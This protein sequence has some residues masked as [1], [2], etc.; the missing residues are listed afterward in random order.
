MDS[1]VWVDWIKRLDVLRDLVC[2]IS[3]RLG[4]GRNNITIA[5]K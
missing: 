5:G 3:M 4:T 2:D 1:S